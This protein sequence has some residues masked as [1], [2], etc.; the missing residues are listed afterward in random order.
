MRLAFF[1]SHFCTSGSFVSFVCCITKGGNSVFTIL[2]V[3]AHCLFSNRTNF[4]RMD[5]RC[6]LT[7]QVG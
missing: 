6:I 7:S 4:L 3:L 1:L 2:T 5:K